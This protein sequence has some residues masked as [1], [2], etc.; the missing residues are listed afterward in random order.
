MENEDLIFEAHDGHRLR[1]RQ[2]IE[3]AKPEA[4]TELEIMEFLLCYVLPRQDVKQNAQNLLDQ[5]GGLPGVF[6]SDP[7]E[8]AR[9][10]GL[11]DVAQE[12]MELLQEF[13]C[14]FYEQENDAPMLENYQ[15]MHKYARS[16]EHFFTAPCSVMLALDENFCPITYS[17]L[18]EGRKWSEPSA[19]ANGLS[20]LL[21]YQPA[22]LM[23]IVYTGKLAS[24]FTEYDMRRLR[25]FCHI[26]TRSN[27]DVMDMLLVNTHHIDSLR[28][29]DRFPDPK[30]TE[31]QQLRR[32]YYTL[33]KTPPDEKERIEKLRAEAARMEREYR[34]FLE[35][36]D[37]GHDDD[38]FI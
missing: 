18:C 30:L 8:M 36:D 17:C 7:G 33:R 3:E 11:G 35:M 34:A 9:S 29:M 10:E 20:D 6:V 16:M 5:F 13:H 38:E 4:L 25:R 24:G 28:L 26:F 31:K 2:R 23:L 14:A 32:E 1:L 27:L 15:L 12:W 37:G 19:L 21:C 22:I